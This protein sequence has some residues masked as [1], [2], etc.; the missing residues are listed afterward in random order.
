VVHGTNNAANAALRKREALME[1]VSKEK[2]VAD[3]KTVIADADELLRAAAASTGEKAAEM[4]E[5]A[6]VM[7]KRATDKMQDLQAAAMEQSKAAARAADDFVHEHPWKA[8]G[9]AAAVGFCLG[10]LVNRR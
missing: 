6:T 1:N 10:L 3:L 9:V 4:R 5:R 7:L 8:V 2:L